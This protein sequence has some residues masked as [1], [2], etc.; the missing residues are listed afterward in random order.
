MN[1]RKR[2]NRAH[3]LPGKNYTRYFDWTTNRDIIDE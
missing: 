1:P 2:W 3:E